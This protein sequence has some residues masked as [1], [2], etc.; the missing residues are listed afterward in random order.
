MNYPEMVCAGLYAVIDENTKQVYVGHT[1]NVLKAFAEH[2]EDIKLGRH[3]CFKTLEL[4]FRLLETVSG[5][6]SRRIKCTEWS[7]KFIKEGYKLVNKRPP[8]QYKIYTKIENTLEFGYLLV[9]QLVNRRNEKITV[10]VFN[11]NEYAE[12][13]IKKYYSETPICKIVYSGNSL[14]RN[15]L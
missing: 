9:V 15:Y 14:T 12:N 3:M 11:K 2:I 10:G 6:K 1:K 5:V 7:T 13:F 8:V 4:E